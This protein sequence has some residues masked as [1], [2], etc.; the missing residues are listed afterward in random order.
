MIKYVRYLC[1]KHGIKYE[2]NNPIHN[3]FGSYIKFL[4][5]NG[6]IESQITAR[7][8][9]SSIGILDL[10]NSVR[11]NQSFAH[12]NPLLNYEE[13]IL[14]FNNISCIIRFIESIESI[15]SKFNKNNEIDHNGLNLE[16][17]TF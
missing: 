14:I 15:E 12:D 1:E 16:D 11:N 8:L 3:L 6:L 13:S 7:I 10:F 17:I 2:K 9:K 4:N 5:K